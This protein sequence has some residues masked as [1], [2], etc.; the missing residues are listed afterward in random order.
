MLGESIAAVKAIV[1]DDSKF[2]A[3]VAAQELSL[4]MLA[5]VWKP[6]SPTLQEHISARGA[7]MEEDLSKIPE[8]PGE[9]CAEFRQ[10]FVNQ[11]PDIVLTYMRELRHKFVAAIMVC[12]AVAFYEVAEMRSQYDRVVQT[13]GFS[14]TLGDMLRVV[15]RDNKVSVTPE[16]DLMYLIHAFFVAVEYLNL[17]EFSKLDEW[18][19]EN[20]GLALLLATDTL[21]RKKVCLLN[22]DKRQEF[23]FLCLTQAVVEPR[24]I[25]SGRARLYACE[26]EVG[27][28]PSYADHD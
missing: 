18:K 10:I 7:K 25:E 11:H 9:D 6:A 21:L 4:T 12:C 19:R 27:R 14:K 5:G 23:P 20:R 28:T 17:C 1:G 22:N 16:A 15:Q 3:D 13:P 2:G 26:E 24:P 8:I